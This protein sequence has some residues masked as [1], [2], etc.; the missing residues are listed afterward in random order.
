MN[1]RQGPIREVLPDDHTFVRQ[2]G[3]LAY[4]QTLLPERQSKQMSRA[5]STFA[6]LILNVG[7]IIPFYP[8]FRRSR[9]EFP[10]DFGKPKGVSERRPEAAGGATDWANGNRDIGAD[11]GRR[12]REKVFEK[13]YENFTRRKSSP[14]R[15]TS[16]SFF[17]SRAQKIS[18]LV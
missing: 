12:G 2:C 1:P 13:S 6:L 10:A 7:W 18:G 3:Y 5:L 17:L 9:R 11:K 14:T 4:R 8:T 15:L 16:K